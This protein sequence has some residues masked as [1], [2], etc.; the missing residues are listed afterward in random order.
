[1]HNT[2]MRAPLAPTLKPAWLPWHS[3]GKMLTRSLIDVYTAKS[4]L[5][6]SWGLTKML[7]AVLGG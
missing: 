1:V 6:A 3:G 5:G 7:P 4:M 2:I